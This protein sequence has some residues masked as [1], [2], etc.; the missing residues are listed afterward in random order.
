MLLPVLATDRDVKNM[1][2][3]HCVFFVVL[4]H[5]VFFCFFWWPILS[6]FN[7]EED[8]DAEV[9]MTSTVRPS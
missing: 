4:I 8:E 5:F 3:L 2:F 6:T 1:F 9:W 7:A